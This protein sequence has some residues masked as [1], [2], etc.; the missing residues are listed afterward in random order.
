MSFSRQIAQINSVT[1]NSGNGSSYNSG[2]NSNYN[3]S[4]G[5]GRASAVMKTYKCRNNAF[6]SV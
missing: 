1:R 3:R 2:S 5:K 6:K 4:K